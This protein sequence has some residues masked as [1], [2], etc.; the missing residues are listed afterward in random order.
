MNQTT[1]WTTPDLPEIEFFTARFTDFS[2]ALH[3][4]EDYAIG[5]VERGVHAFRYRGENFA[6]PA[7]RV[8]TCQPGEV[9]NGYPGNAEPWYYRMMYLHPS[10]VRRVAT[11]LGHRPSSLPFLNTTTIDH[12]RVVRAVYALHQYAEAAEPT[13]AQEVLVHDMLALVLGHF[14]EIQVNPRAVTDE[15]TPVGRAIT[16][17]SDRYTDDLQLEDLANAAHL[18]KSYFIRAFRRHTGMSP[19]AY[20]VQVRLNRAKA[21][22]RAGASATDVAQQT[23]FYDQSHL[24]KAFKRFMGV[25][26]G[27]YALAIG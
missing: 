20:L 14:S 24:T 13:L 9:H 22:L 4:H 25:P 19:Y 7:G 26:P 2:Y 3:F 6:V 12:Q 18:S 21:L 11:E 15:R 8:V 16:L 17:M 10:L 23:G 1:V 27:Q 5:V